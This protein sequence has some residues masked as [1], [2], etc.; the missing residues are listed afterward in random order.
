[1]SSG[2]IPALSIILPTYNE[3]R[4]IHPLIKE[5]RT[6]LKRAHIDAYE[7][8]FVDDSS[9]ET[10]NVIESYAATDERVRLIHRPP[11][12]RTGLATAFVEGFNAARGD[13]LCCMDSDLQH[14]PA[15]VP[16]TLRALSRS[17]ADIVVASRYMRGGSAAG[18]GSRMR[19]LI[20]IGTKY[21]SQLILSPARLTSD[22]GSGFFAFKRSVI[23]GVHLSPSGF[24]ILLEILVRGNARKVTD[25]PYA[26]LARE[27]EESKA[28]FSQGIRFL[29][30]V[31][32]LFSSVPSASRFIRF[33]VVGASGTL[34][35]IA[36]LTVFYEFVRMPLYGAWLSAVLV[37]IATNFYLNN[38]FTF[39]DQQA[40]NRSEYI[41]KLSS[42]A[43]FSFVSLG[44][45]FLFFSATLSLGSHYI[46]AALAGIVGA[47]A[48]NFFLAKRVV[49]AGGSIA[50]R[51][52]ALL[53]STSRTAVLATVGA[54]LSGYVLLA[55]FIAYPFPIALI[56]AISLALTIQGMFSLYLM[57]YAW[58][59]PE[60]TRHGSPEH[61]LPPRHSFTAI[62]PARHE[63]EVIST[64]LHTINAIE[65]PEHLKEVRVVC[66]VDD[67]ETI[68]EVRR[69]MAVLNN[70]RIHL[71]VFAGLPINK[72]HGLNFSL[73]M[74]EG[75]I[76]TIFDA[77]DD[78][79]PNIY[80]IIDS[81]Y[82]TSKADVVQ[83]GVQLMNHDTNWYSLFNVLEYFFWFKSNLHFF[84]HMNL[85]PLAGNTV[86]F[87]RRWLTRI[88]G[89][90]ENCLT[91]D[92]DIGIRLSA[93]GANVRVIYDKEHVTREETPPTL[94]SFIRQRTRWNQG[95]I[96][97]LL[98]GS[99]KDLPTKRQ[100][101][102]AIY[103]LTWPI[104]QGVLFIYTPI[105]FLLA[106]LLKMPV[107]VALIANLPLYMLGAFLVVYN[108]GLYEFL[109]DYR[110]PYRWYYPLLSV[111]YF[112]PFQ[113]ALGLSA[114]RAV[115]RTLRGMTAWE[116]TQHANIHRE[117]APA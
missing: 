71:D 38:R 32:D 20:S 9:D 79:H 88:G 92:A 37:S 12:E 7:L 68:A 62:V 52:T 48:V 113:V 55:L 18:L 2:T 103:I 16:R 14:P 35:N 45:N 6:H 69:T 80:R 31:W 30:H 5:L 101:A 73:P 106:F 117:V 76:V 13:V 77:E 96:Q 99:W 105:A 115:Y 61:L 90:D 50:E 58:E 104:V 54:L 114:F 78:P 91:E 110:K 70:P 85:T 109:R 43:V 19:K 23:E 49:W 111:L 97:I 112:Y 83:S 3:T 82:Q 34:I 42:Y 86:F 51:V 74:A 60:H 57:I 66:R 98:K 95:F 11:E 1:M 81:V 84:S 64:T 53:R 8:L 46:L 17:R 41:E 102:L 21:F 39:P 63:K 116:K 29:L 22:P 94:M 89:W 25:V 33:A 72:P 75:D 108:L 15:V 59:S 100:K 10:P 40:R 4:N 27:N 93:A 107:V 65:Y 36:I 44:A 67:I 47:L 26:F 87:K 28:T 24:K 56:A